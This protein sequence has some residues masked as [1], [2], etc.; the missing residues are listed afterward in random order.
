MKKIFTLLSVCMMFMGTVAQ[1]LDYKFNW[2]TS[3]EGHNAQA[4][5]VI[6][7]DNT[8]DGNYFASLV[9]GG[10]TAA[11]KTISWG[12][13]N[14]QDA[15]G[16]DIEGAD[17]S[18][19]NS[20]TPN[21]LFAKIDKTTGNPIWNVYTNFGYADCENSAFAATADGGA[22][23]LMHV[24]QSEKADYR[25]A[26][27]VDA[28][29]TVTYLQH[30]DADQW[31]YRSVLI[32][33]SGEGKVEWTRTINALDLT[34]N[35]AKANRPLYTS[36]IK[37]AADGKI[38]VSGR[39]CTTMYFTGKG[40]SIVAKEAFYNEG[41]TGD[42]Q[43]NTGNAF[44]AEFDADGYF[45][46]LITFT[47]QDAGYAYTQAN[48][49]VID[50]TTMYVAGLAKNGAMLNPTLSI[51][52]LEDNTVKTYKELTVGNNSGGKQNFKIYSLQ[53]IGNSLYMT[54]NLVGTLTDNN[55]TLTTTGTASQLYGYVARFDTEG[56]MLA[57]K[58]YGTINTGIV[59]VAEVNG[60]IVA[61][62]WQMVKNEVSNAGT[63]ALAYDKELNS[64]LSRTL[65]IDGGMTAAAA[66]PLF[67]GE[68]L[69]VLSRGG[70][71][72]ATQSFYGTTDV[73]PALTQSFGVQFGSW[74]VSGNIS[75]GISGVSAANSGAANLYGIDGVSA[76]SAD[77]AGNGVYVANGKKVV[78]KK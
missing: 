3:I 18:S 41:W 22:V 48:R 66:A 63:V 75:T 67:D 24:R 60:G 70:K 6:G 32:K 7:V 12:G 76:G 26:N 31:A 39:M 23:V 58:N 54:G 4:A 17:Y 56:N 47:A 21:L 9:W 30:T 2:G 19:G 49:M 20:Y 10:T 38:Y 55:V 73:K 29:G 25:L 64:E 72:T 5:N 51:I 35:G 1:G 33:I 69:V 61:I 45:N 44:V 53:L 57:A 8:A 52:N 40:G 13:Q 14:L 34:K 77:K 59:G 62:A 27:I 65:I 15:N 74:K 50:G 36:D 16:Q 46:N 11:G 37:V 43:T 71:A 42:S 78:I 68:N 28:E